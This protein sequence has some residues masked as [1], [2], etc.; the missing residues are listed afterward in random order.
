MSNIPLCQ[1]C[2]TKIYM[3][4]GQRGYLSQGDSKYHWHRFETPEK[5]DDHEIPSNAFNIQRGNRYI[6]YETPQQPR[7][8]LFHN[9]SCWEQ[10]HLDHRDDLER[11][12]RSR[13][14]WKS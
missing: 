6:D 7:D 8:G 5:R 14:E 13:G 1:Q 12:I 11:V 10:W 9:H 3:R 4:Y 2:G